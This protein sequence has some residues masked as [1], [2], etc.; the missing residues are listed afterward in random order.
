MMR[1]GEIIFERM[2][3]LNNLNLMILFLFDI[4]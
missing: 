4:G 1:G 3:G 2:M